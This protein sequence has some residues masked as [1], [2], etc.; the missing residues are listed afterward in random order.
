M[1]FGFVCVRL[2][3]DDRQDRESDRMRNVDLDDFS[4]ES[5]AMSMAVAS[6][7]KMEASG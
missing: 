4:T 1:I 3:R 5:N 7:E 2:F 6:A